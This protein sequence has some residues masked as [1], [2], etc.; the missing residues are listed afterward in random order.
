[1]FYF[2]PLT[3]P[4]GPQLSSLIRIRPYVRY[5]ARLT[6]YE[7]VGEGNGWQQL[8]GSRFFPR[9][10]PE[11][12]HKNPA[13]DPYY[14][15][16]KIKISSITSRVGF[17][18][19]EEGW[20]PF[21]KTLK[22]YMEDPHLTYD[23]SSLARL[24][25][26]FC[27]ENVQEVLLDHIKDSLKPFCEWPPT[28]ELVSWVWTLNRSSV[29][30]YLQHHR[31]RG[32]NG[33]WIFFGPHNKEY[34]RKEF[35]RLISLYNSIK[36]TGYQE[37]LSGADPV[38]GYFLRDGKNI[39]FV[40]LQGNHRVSALKVAGYTDVDVLIRQGHPAVIDRK[41]LHRWTEAGGGIYPV[42]L[43]ESLFGVLLNGSGFQK[44]QRYGLT[45]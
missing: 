33:G 6:G 14:T 23:D 27:P 15:P 11:L 16:F 39:R 7:L 25:T 42:S 35:Q 17:S 9:R 22:E 13:E 19:A 21:V 32:E 37:K 29:D 40:L 2:N 26:Q 31:R 36:S 43:V 12:I 44:A 20:H 41:E 38:N 28:Y 3:R 1:M 30:S 5:L 8:L 45:V 18:Y 10:L 4:G 24:Y 34:G